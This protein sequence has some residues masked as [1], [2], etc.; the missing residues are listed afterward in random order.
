MITVISGGSLPYCAVAL[1]QLSQIFTCYMNTQPCY[2]ML[3]IIPRGGQGFPQT[4]SYTDILAYVISIITMCYVVFEPR[5]SSKFVGS[6]AHTFVRMS[7]CPIV[8]L[9]VFVN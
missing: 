9:S 3:S 7:F 6:S 8:H 1:A 4:V 5:A 2:L